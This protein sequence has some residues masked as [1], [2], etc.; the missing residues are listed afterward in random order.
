MKPLVS[1]VVFALCAGLF[2]QEKPDA[3]KL[4]LLGE[5]LVAKDKTTGGPLAKKFS[6]N[7][8]RI[9][10]DSESI[11]AGRTATYKLQPK[12][13]LKQIDISLEEGPKDEQGTYLGIFEVKGDTL[14]IHLAAPGQPR[15]TSFDA[16]PTTTLLVLTKSKKG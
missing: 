8:A 11:T 13:N 4:P 12:E 1:G 10:I 7:V 5:W 6:E 9:T 2:A 14:Q 3:D 15:P 16:K